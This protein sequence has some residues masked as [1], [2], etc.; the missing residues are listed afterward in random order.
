MRL[1]PRRGPQQE[2]FQIRKRRTPRRPPQAAYDA[3]VIRAT[4]ALRNWNHRFS[5]ALQH[6]SQT[7]SPKSST[8]GPRVRTLRVCDDPGDHGRLTKK[9]WVGP[10]S[11]RPDPE[12]FDDPA[13]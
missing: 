5:I 8:E 13:P 12:S 6:I 11:R 3:H 10:S 2:Q 4:S 7:P 9:P 1:R